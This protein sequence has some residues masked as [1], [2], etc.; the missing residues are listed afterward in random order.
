[1]EKKTFTGNRNHEEMIIRLGEG[2]QRERIIHGEHK[3]HVGS[4]DEESNINHGNRE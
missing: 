4:G 1:M 2:K 3:N